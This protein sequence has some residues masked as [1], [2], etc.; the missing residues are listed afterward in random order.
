[1]CFLVYPI[2]LSL[3]HIQ[4]RTYNS[5]LNRNN[6]W[7]VFLISKILNAPAIYSKINIIRK[8]NE[9]FIEIEI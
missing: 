6:N 4:L 2:F 1:M 7:T 3:L 5:N 8:Y 9:W